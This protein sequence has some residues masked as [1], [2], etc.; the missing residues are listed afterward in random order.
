MFNYAKNR[1]RE[2]D[3]NLLRSVTEFLPRLGLWISIQICNGKTIPTQ[4]STWFWKN[5]ISFHVKQNFAGYLTLRKGQP[6]VIWQATKLELNKTK[7]VRASDAC[8]PAFK[9][10]LTDL[11]RIGSCKKKKKSGNQ[12]WTSVNYDFLLYQCTCSQSNKGTHHNIFYFLITSLQLKLLQSV[13]TLFISKLS[14]ALH[15]HI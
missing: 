5:I 14:A 11:K 1:L 7:L 10:A 4:I 13:P 6:W 15:T 12:Q 3:T 9:F 2:I 8:M